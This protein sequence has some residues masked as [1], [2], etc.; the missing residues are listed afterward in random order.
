M[1]D[2]ST[3]SRTCWIQMCRISCRG[4]FQQI[5]HGAPTTHRTSM[6]RSGQ[7]WPARQQRTRAAKKFPKKVKGEF[8]SMS[9][10]CWVVHCFAWLRLRCKNQSLEHSLLVR[11]LATNLLLHAP[12][13]TIWA[14]SS[15]GIA[16]SKMSPANSRSNSGLPWPRPYPH[17]FLPA[18]NLKILPRDGG[19]KW[20]GSM[21][22]SCGSKLQ[23]VDL[24]Y[25]LQQAS[26]I[27]RS[28]FGSRFSCS[29]F[30]CSWSSVPRSGCRC[31]K[32][33]FLLSKMVRHQSQFRQRIL[34]KVGSKA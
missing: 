2:A 28:H 14:A 17:V 21:L 1:W 6:V 30:S 23:H 27:I 24:Q 25:H 22:T 33:K 12:R 16:K 15:E 3:I 18:M 29:R 10:P 8:I 7:V 9:G 26:K 32:G 34:K 20:L 13:S 11:P 19:L 31:P 5:T 4:S